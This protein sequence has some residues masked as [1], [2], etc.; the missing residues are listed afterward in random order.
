MIPSY[1]WKTQHLSRFAG[2][3][4]N[5]IFIKTIRFQFNSIQLLRF[6]SLS[7]NRKLCL[8]RIKWELF[9][10]MNSIHDT[11]HYTM[12][13]EKK[14]RRKTT[15]E[16]FDVEILFLSFCTKQRRTKLDEKKKQT[17][18]ERKTSACLLFVFVWMRFFFLCLL[19]TSTLYTDETK[20]CN[21]T[22]Q[23]LMLVFF[24]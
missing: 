8:S 19:P 10:M 12:K 3:T 4:I 18:N 17:K 9:Q 23:M 7:R 16:C 5:T 14:M 11:F 13:I 21:L 15:T 24:L 20:P 1:L 6:L 2:L 22:M